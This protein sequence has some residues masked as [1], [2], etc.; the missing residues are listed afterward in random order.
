MNTHPA[1]RLFGALQKIQETSEQA[2]DRMLRDAGR[3]SWS[4]SL[5]NDQFD[6]LTDSDKEIY[7]AASRAA[8]SIPDRLEEDPEYIARQASRDADFDSAR[9]AEG[10]R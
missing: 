1:N 10:H 4:R 5:T 7:C 9:D 2:I 8:C 6:A 3:P